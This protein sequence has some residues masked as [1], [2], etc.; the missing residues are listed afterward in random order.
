MLDC[1]PDDRW[2]IRIELI[3]M[4]DNVTINLMLNAN[5]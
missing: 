4:N 5:Y 3:I 1:Q 2:M